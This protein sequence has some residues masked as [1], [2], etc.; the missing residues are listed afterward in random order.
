MK[1]KNKDYEEYLKTAFEIRIRKNIGQ[2]ILA[3]NFMEV[4]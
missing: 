1:M 4:N 2:T 3:K